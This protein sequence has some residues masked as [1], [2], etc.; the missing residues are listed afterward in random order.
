MTTAVSPVHVNKWMASVKSMDERN[1]GR[2]LS[3]EWTHL[4]AR[5]CQPAGQRVAQTGRKVLQRRGWLNGGG[6]L[7][8][9]CVTAGT[10]RSPRYSLQW[11]L[12]R[13]LGPTFHSSTSQP[14]ASRPRPVYLQTVV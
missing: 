7:N 4:Q 12:R 10:Q 13:P 14:C 5:F 2:F 6:V 9:Q 8:L 1:N 11:A 3:D